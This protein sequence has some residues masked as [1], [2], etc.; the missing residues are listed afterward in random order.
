MA[1]AKKA[2]SVLFN[3]GGKLDQSLKTA[4]ED[5]QKLV[6]KAGKKTKDQQLMDQLVGRHKQA[7]KGLNIASQQMSKAWGDVGR[8]IMVPLRNIGL[9]AA[10]GGAAAYSIASKTAKWG[11]EVYKGAQKIGITTE[12]MSKLAYAAQKS[13]VSTTELSTGMRNLRQNITKAIEGNADA[14]LAF[15]R[16][17]DHFNLYNKDGSLKKTD[18]ILIEVSDRFKKMADAGVDSVYMLDLATTVFGNRAGAALMPLLVEG[19]EGIEAMRKEAEEMGIVF[20]DVSGKNAAE[21]QD[22]IA[23]IKAA[24]RGLIMTIGKPLLEPLTKI[25][26]ALGTWIAS[27]RELVSV[28]VNEF[29][30][31]IRDS[32]PRIKEFLYEA[33]DA[34]VGVIRIVKGLIDRLGGPEEALKK[35]AKAWLALQGLKILFALGGAIKKTY[36][37]GQALH[38]L[39]I[40]TKTLAKMKF[41]IVLG[42]SIAAVFSVAAL[43]IIAIVAAL[44]AIGVGAFLL[45]RAIIKNWDKIKQFFVNVWDAIKGFFSKIGDKIKAFWSGLPDVLKK[46]LIGAAI[47]IVGGLIAFFVGKKVA[48]VA[49]ATAMWKGVLLGVKK[50]LPSLKKMLNWRM[51]VSGVLGLARFFEVTW[52]KTK[53]FFIELWQKVTER[54]KELWE[55]VKN[56]FV[57]IWEKVKEIFTGFIDY[58]KSLFED[59][60]VKGIL[61]VLAHFSPVYLIMKAVNK[62]FDIDLIQ[63][64]KDWMSGF[65]SGILDA[66]RN[67]VSL[68][69][70]AVSSLIPNPIKNLFSKGGSGVPAF[71]EGGIV[72]RPTLA[73]V[74]EDGAEAIIP[75]NKPDRAREIIAQITPKMSDS[76]GGG[77]KSAGGV[78]FNFSPVIHINGNADKSV[79]DNSLNDL[80]RKFEKWLTDR[81][82]N[83]MRTQLT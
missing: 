14:L 44:A 47:A 74:G 58:V 26:E 68:V 43:K 16:V 71:A 2:F 9:L 18:E 19:S 25:Q 57:N 5:A 35:I 20:D 3:I 62:I 13:N 48:V 31:R 67:A 75:L 37:F 56:F 50:I 82:R 8:S 60:F 69:G 23:K 64:G 61:R 54:F 6:A 15:R 27:N 49:A 39:F 72:K 36:Y 45:T 81:E 12:A 1:D 53:E 32:L 80:K 40:V 4:T 63:L 77:G 34:V 73:M 28:K 79:I 10:A 17:D 38:K 65:V 55:N 42:K 30:E 76:S 70:D 51:L 21:F 22:S 52:T 11:D 29:L 7:M 41:I 66:L 59:G 24:F 33:R 78:S 83:L 46:I